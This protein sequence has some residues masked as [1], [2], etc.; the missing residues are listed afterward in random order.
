MPNR[1]RRTATVACA[2]DELLE[3]LES[4]PDRL[5]RLNAEPREVAA[6]AS[7]ALDETV[8]HSV[9][10]AVMMTEIVDVACL[11]AGSAGPAAEDHVHLETDELGGQPGKRSG[12]PSAPRGSVTK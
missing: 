8:A 9:G 11:R 6:W 4:L 7:E 1:S 5:Y 3:Q 10:E 2:W 12:L